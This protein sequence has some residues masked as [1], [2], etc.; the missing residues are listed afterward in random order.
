M[1]QL[2]ELSVNLGGS[3][4]LRELNLRMKEGESLAVQGP[5]GCGKST[6]LYTLLG[7]VPWQQGQYLFSGDRVTCDN[8]WKVR[9]QIG[10]IPQ[11]IAAGSQSTE[12]FLKAP[13]SLKTHR[14][15]RYNPE[16]IFQLSEQLQLSG[17][18]LKQPFSSLSGGQQQRFAIIRALQF[19]PRLIIA[20][21][22]TS[23]LDRRARSSVIE[24]LL[25]RH[26]SILSTSHD[27]IWLEQCQRIIQM[28]NGALTGSE[29]E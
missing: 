10:Y 9:S 1:L 28:E 15:K 24:L 2:K 20:D 5:S 26:T 7:A 3:P 19:S 17:K 11:K 14:D 12:E 8:I 25:K 29:D 23:A 13:F 27:P 16:S 22:P 6:L 18:L 4:I 21:E